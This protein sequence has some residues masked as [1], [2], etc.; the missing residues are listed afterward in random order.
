MRIVFFVHSIVSDWNNGH[1]HFL[2]GLA[3]ALQRRGHQLLICE[4]RQNW[5]TQN[6]FEE[7]G[8]QALLEFAQVFAHLPVAFY[9]GGDG[10]IDEVEGLTRDADL[11]IVH[12]FNEPELVGA[13][14]DVRR[15]RDDFLLL[16]HDT[17]HRALSTPQQIA[18]LNLAPYDGV[19][20]F[21]EVLTA[22]Y[23]QR[24]GLA[25]WTLHEAA[26]TDLFRPLTEE[27]TEDVLWI[28]NWGD[29]ERSGE[30]RAYLVEP[31][32]SLPNLRFAVHGVRY[33]AAAREELTAAGV[34][35]RGRLANHRVPQALARTRLTVHIPR[36]YYRQA[37]PGVPTIRPF[38]A[39]ACGT[40]LLSLPWADPEG[41]FRA[42]RDYLLAHSPEEM[43]RQ[44]TRLTQSEE[45]GAALAASG[46]ERIRARHTC[47]HRAEELAAICG[48]LGLGG[49]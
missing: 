39:L 38:E 40:P 16:F 1:V 46:L 18:R 11:V 23:R 20:A 31:A 48:Q 4:Q 25:A 21:G 9:A 14:A 22:I 2:R 10:L 41:L 13:L 43:A 49:V 30:L 5:S 34:A 6:L 45:A 44:M 29:E 42:G 37:L 3:A 32:R 33:P 47:A 36:R 28:G 26:D 19:L 24:F 17:H 27:K 8:A 12:E 15:R 7:E 35:F